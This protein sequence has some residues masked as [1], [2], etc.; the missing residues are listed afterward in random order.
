MTTI[1]LMLLG[2]FLLWRA[3]VLFIE[4]VRCRYCGVLAGHDEHCPY[5]GTGL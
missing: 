2:L 5:A 1:T 3:A 4:K